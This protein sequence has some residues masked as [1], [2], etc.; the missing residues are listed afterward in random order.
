MIGVNIKASHE[1]IE[2]V[3]YLTH[4][5]FVKA[6]RDFT[7]FVDYTVINLA[8]HTNISGIQQYYKKG[9]ALDKLLRNVH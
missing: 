8:D 6:I 4:L 2:T 9:P 1:T 7:E 3:P 5:D